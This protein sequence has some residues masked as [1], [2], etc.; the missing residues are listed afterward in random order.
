MR[1][2]AEEKRSS[3]RAGRNRWAAALLLGLGACSLAGAAHGQVLSSV[4]AGNQC[5]HQSG[6]LTGTPLG[7][8]DVG[9]GTASCLCACEWEYEV[10]KSTEDTH[11]DGR[12]V[13]CRFG[14]LQAYS[15]YLHSKEGD[16]DGHG[17][18]FDTCGGSANGSGSTISDFQFQ[19]KLINGCSCCKGKIEARGSPRFKAIVEINVGSGV[20]TA[21]TGGHIIEDSTATNMKADLDGSMTLTG[22]SSAATVSIKTGGVGASVNIPIGGT[23]VKQVK[24]FVTSSNDWKYADTETLDVVG[25]IHMTVT[26]DASPIAL[27]PVAMAAARIP[28]KESRRMIEVIA[29]CVGGCDVRHTVTFED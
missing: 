25:A 15:V 26:A 23:A 16:I 6:T 21:T 12:T 27:N 3:W 19:L 1:R 20:A 5:K 8:G 9:I 17:F 28:D 11:Q 24:T 29:E 13:S 18:A 22:T 14:G 7:G 2:V 4:P 10:T